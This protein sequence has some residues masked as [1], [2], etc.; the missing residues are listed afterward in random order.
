MAKFEDEVKNNMFGFGQANEAYAK[1]FF[2]KSF[3]KCISKWS[4]I[5][6]LAIVT[7]SESFN[8]NNW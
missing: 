2:G 6:H 1:Y 5:N 7:K 8:D 4:M 3:F